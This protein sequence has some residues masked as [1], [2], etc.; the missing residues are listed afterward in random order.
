[1]KIHW[2]FLLEWL[3]GMCVLRVVYSMWLLATKDNYLPVVTN[4]ALTGRPNEV[5]LPVWG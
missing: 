5:N 1:M 3:A 4:L 2:E